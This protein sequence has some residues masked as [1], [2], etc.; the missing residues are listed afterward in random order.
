MTIIPTT[1]KSYDL[2]VF[3]WAWGRFDNVAPVRPAVVASLVADRAAL[4]AAASLSS[5]GIG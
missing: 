1:I 2:H 5:E 4:A 3:H